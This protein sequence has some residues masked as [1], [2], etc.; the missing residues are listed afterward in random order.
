MPVVDPGGQ[1]VGLSTLGN[2]TP[3]SLAALFQPVDPTIPQIAQ[4]GTNLSRPNVAPIN[5][6]R[7]LGLQTQPAGWFPF[8]P[9]PSRCSCRHPSGFPRGFPFCSVLLITVAP[10]QV[11]QAGRPIT[12]SCRSPSG[13]LAAI[14]WFRH[15]TKSLDTAQRHGMAIRPLGGCQTPRLGLLRRDVLSQAPLMGEGGG[16]FGSGKPAGIAVRFSHSQ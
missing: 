15:S 14:S 12:A 10:A 8:E 7:L 16:A 11:P 9:P 5:A 4:Y 6:A 13:S 3:T 1:R 2:T